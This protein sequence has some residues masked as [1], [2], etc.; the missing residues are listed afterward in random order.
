MIGLVPEDEAALLHV[1]TRDVDLDGVHR[2]IV[3]AA[4]ELL[5]LADGSARDV[6]EEAGLAEVE[7][8]KDPVDH[9]AAPRVLEPDGVEHSG[10]GSRTRG[11]ADCRAGARGSCTLRQTAPRVPVVEAVDPGVLLT[12][13]HAPGEEDDRGGEGEAAQLD[14]EA[15]TRFLELARGGGGG[16]HGGPRGGTGARSS[17]VDYSRAAPSPARSAPPGAQNRIIDA[18]ACLMARYAPPARPGLRGVP[19]APRGHPAPARR[20]SRSPD[21][22]GPAL[23][24]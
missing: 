4:R 5:V 6:G 9:L 15:R 13:P 21:G 22:P 19:A 8:G 7:G 17:V 2:G 23:D 1:G 16:R 18:R 10:T 20:E 11:A 14:G 12:E 24:V 3:E